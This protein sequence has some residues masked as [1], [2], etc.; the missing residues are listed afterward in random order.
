MTNVYRLTSAAAT[1]LL[2]Q[3]A[4]PI[5]KD[6]LTPGRLYSV[7]DFR[8]LLKENGIPT[9]NCEIDPVIEI[10]VSEDILEIVEQE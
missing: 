1:A 10:L 4:R 9:F 5:L 7:D 6:H 8:T 3:K 2:L